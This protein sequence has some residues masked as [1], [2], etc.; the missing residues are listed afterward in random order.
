MEFKVISL[1]LPVYVTPPGASW[2][3]RRR[4][5]LGQ[6]VPSGRRWRRK[7]A[8]WRERR[9]S[10]WCSRLKDRSSHVTCPSWCHSSCRPS[11]RGIESERRCQSWRNGHALPVPGRGVRRRTLCIENKTNY[12]RWFTSSRLRR[13]WAIRVSYKAINVYNVRG[14]H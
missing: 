9:N 14:L 1:F 8:Q 4:R 13:R 5:W 2:G 12:Y 6:T 10:S 11:R 7:W 3:R